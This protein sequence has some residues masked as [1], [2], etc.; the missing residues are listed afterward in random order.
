M[1]K[2]E[3]PYLSHFLGPMG[4]RSE[5]AS[6]LLKLV[7]DDHVHW[8]RNYFPGDATTFTPRQ[9]SEMLDGTDQLETAVLQ[10]VAELRRSFPFHSPRYLA[11]QQSEAS[12][13]SLIG[14]F[15]G[16]L[17]NANNVTTESGNVTFELELT[18]ASRLLDMVGFTPPP[19]P[20]DVQHGP[21]LDRYFEQ[22]EQPHGWSHLCS[23]G[24]S[25]NIEALWV[26]RNVAIGAFRVRHAARQLD[27]DA[28]V[29]IGGT[30]VRFSDLDDDQLLDLPSTQKLS[31]FQDLVSAD[32][33]Q[34][35]LNAFNEAEAPYGV[36]Q[37]LVV[38]AP[39]T[40]HYSIA[41]AANVLGLGGV[42]AVPTDS[43]HRMS[44]PE[45][46]QRLLE[47]REPGG[48]RPLAVVAVLGTTE[49]GAIDPLKPILDVR[50]KMVSE[51]QMGFWVHA[52]AAWGGFFASVLRLGPRERCEAHVLRA[53][54]DAGIEPPDG[55]LLTPAVAG[56]VIDAL[57][58]R[59]TST[60]GDILTPHREYEAA[61]EQ[62]DWSAAEH[63]LKA[64][65]VAA[66]ANGKELGRNDIKRQITYA[67][68]FDLDLLLPGSMA[69]QPDL[70]A[71]TTDR[72][73]LEHGKP[74][75]AAFDDPDVLDAIGALAD[76]DSVTIDPHKMGYAHYPCGAVAFKT[77]IVRA[78]VAQ[79]A[80]Y[81]TNSKGQSQFTPLRRMERDGKGVRKVVE[82]PAIYTLEGSRPAGPATSTWLASEVM[83]YEQGHHGRLAIDAYR[84]ARRLFE[85][86]LAWPQFEEQRYGPH[87]PGFRFIPLSVDQ[88]GNF[89]P[90][91]TNLVIFAVKPADSTRL[92]DMNEL[93]K[94]V[95]AKFS[96]SAE[97]GTHEYSYQQP[98]FLSSTDFKE[99]AYPLD[100]VS[101]I[102]R[103]AGL[104]DFD[105]TYPTEGL[106]VLRSTVMNPYLEARR[107]WNR[108]D[109]VR[110][111]VIAL[112]NTVVEALHEKA[113]DFEQR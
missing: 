29:D 2:Q 86:L 61:C 110:D 105:A 43:R 53:Y 23:G 112:R 57:A 108:G 93:T 106:K 75:Q 89:A 31:V 10:L 70:S 26:A 3:F 18:V 95:E 66:G 32:V 65:L 63:A 37:R 98:F 6:R 15:A 35:F 109:E 42:R 81:I 52:D 40:A 102:G 16:Q 73:P 46:E 88:A 113:G 19:E 72:L 56:T 64:A 100:S 17:Y 24:T 41:K 104:D 44:I 76:A 94:A 91:D 11:H 79:K 87:E 27:L 36:L 49:D 68:S 74:G 4:E 8:R 69:G 30:P 82:S 83:P 62:Q 99:P 90:P 101:S 78:F 96:I 7:F 103:A 12:L 45:L 60:E 34:K 67:T 84:A 28:T 85:W 50:S 77:D 9:R 71:T 47:C 33:D 55:Q 48:D 5:V 59:N 97:A 111:F 58:E 92:Q 22:L 25:A 1:T 51:H 14:L 21:A 20:P 38:F 80:P 13:P 39:G 107:A 54:A